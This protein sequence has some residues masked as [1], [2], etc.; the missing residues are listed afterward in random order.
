MK[1]ILYTL[2]IISIGIP[3]MAQS[4]EGMITYNRKTDW[5]AIMSKLPWMT[6]EDIDRSTLTWGSN[7]DN[8]GQNYELSFKD[9]VSVYT[10]KEEEES[11]GTYSWKQ[12]KLFIIRDYKNK[13]T[14]DL[15]EF[16]G[17]DYHIEDASPKYKWKILNEIKEVAGYICMKAETINTVKD[18][19]IVAWFTDGI[20][21]YGGPEGYDGLPGTI[22]EL[23]INNGA[24]VITATKVDLVTPVE[25][26][27]IPKKMKG[28]QISYEE[29]NSK[30]E[31]FIKDSMEGRKNPFWRVRY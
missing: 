23:D 4:A 14:N 22:M 28:K 30:L 1:N 7:S 20:A 2:L 17:T 26:L 31:D 9:N 12:E 8:K 13:T 10:Y 18:Q 21:F 24:A 3:A 29:Y 16:V 6:Q 25:S 19:T 27:P 11:E 5:I 15:I